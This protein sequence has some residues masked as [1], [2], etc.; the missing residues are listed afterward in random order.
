PSPGWRAPSTDAAAAIL[1]RVVHVYVARACEIERL[2]AKEMGEPLQQGIEGARLAGSIYRWYATH[3]PELLRDEQFDPQGAKES[4][5]QTEPI[6]PLVGVMPWN[7]PYYQVARFVAPNL[8]AGNTIIL[9][10]AGI[11]AAS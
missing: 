10:H 5:V 1:A 11:C 2:I 4:L 8:M 6:G 7:Y 3:G 9:K